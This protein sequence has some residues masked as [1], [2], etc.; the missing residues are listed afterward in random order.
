MIVHASLSRQDVDANGLINSID[1]AQQVQEVCIKGGGSVEDFFVKEIGCVAGRPFPVAFLFAWPSVMFDFGLC[2][3]LTLWTGVY[4]HFSEFGR[5]STT[6][7]DSVNDGRYRERYFVLS[8]MLRPSSTRRCPS[9][10]P[11]VPMFATHQ[12]A[13]W[14]RQWPLSRGIMRILFIMRAM[15]KF[16]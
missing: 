14:R 11:L 15:F 5:S 8:G 2:L 1:L 10:L 12:G 7:C 16:L 13:K 3:F 6:E 4:A 9:C